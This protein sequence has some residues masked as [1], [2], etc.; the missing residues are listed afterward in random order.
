MAS[1]TSTQGSYL[2]P[3]AAIA[4]AQMQQMAAFNVNGLVAAPMTPSSGTSTPPG[5]AAPIGVNG[6]SA[7]P[8]QSNGQPASEPIYT[9][10]I[11]P[12]PGS[13]LTSL[14]PQ[15]YAGV[16]HYAGESLLKFFVL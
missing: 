12:Y 7:L 9:N 3:M 13:M 6:F 2:N 4:A 1:K 10:G 8:P 14:Y 11:H 5:I 16:Q 15:A